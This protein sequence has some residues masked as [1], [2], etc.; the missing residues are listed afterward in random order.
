M[1]K[2]VSLIIYY[3]VANKL[4]SSYFPLGKLFNSI[5]FFLIKQF[6]N[7]LGKN[8]KIQ[9]NVRFGNGKEI[10]IGSFCAINE[11][12]YIQKASIGNYVMIAPNVAIIGSSHDFESVEI[13]MIFQGTNRN[14]GPTIDDDVWIGR[15][16]IIMPGVQIGKGSIIGAGAV[17]TKD[18]EPYSIVG[19]VPAKLIKYRKQN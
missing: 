15:N 10:T 11:N 8:T 2:Q 13:P 6:I 5:R 17:V 14:I 9:Q 7:Q 12:V 19:G 18:I 3:L 1:K 16:A 4:P